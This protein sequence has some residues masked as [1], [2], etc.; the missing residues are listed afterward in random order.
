MLLSRFRE[1]L[2]SSEWAER[3]RVPRTAGFAIL[4]A[5]AIRVDPKVAPDSSDIDMARV[6]V[7]TLPQDATSQA[8]SSLLCVIDSDPPA[9]AGPALME[10]GKTLEDNGAYELAADVYQLA[11]ELGRREQGLKLAP[12]ALVRVGACLRNIGKYPEA[13]KAYRAAAAVAQE[14]G[15]YVAELLSE[16]GRAKVAIE[17]DNYGAARRQLDRVIVAARQ[18]DLRHPLAMA[19]HDRGSLSNREGDLESALVDLAESITLQADRAHQIRVLADVGVTLR[20]LGLIDIARDVFVCVHDE[21][22]KTD[23]RCAQ[24]INLMDIAAYQQQWDDFDRLRRQLEVMDLS[25]Y[26][27]CEFL[28]TLAEGMAL[29]GFEAQARATYEVLRETAR[30]G[31]R[32]EFERRAQRALDG[33][34]TSRTTPRRELA[35]PPRCRPAIDVIRETVPSR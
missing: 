29:R 8:L 22:P 11:A 21:S 4:Q 17:Q 16:V 35:L 6:V 27:Q 34:T 14:I 18:R 31:G 9:P 30:L 10:Y 19:L 2:R 1:Q 12:A 5:I 20:Q 25:P 13:E 33:E 7:D 28:D 15:D 32:H 3:E 23:T 26:R 24:M